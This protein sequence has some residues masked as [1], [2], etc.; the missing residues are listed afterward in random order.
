MLEERGEIDAFRARY[1]GLRRYLPAFFALPFQGEPGSE[2]ILQGLE[3]VRQLDA[4]T[5]Q[6]FP[7]LAPTAFVPGKFRPALAEPMG[8]SIGA[9]GNSGW[10]SRSA[11]ACVRGMSSCPRVAATSPLPT[12]SMIPPV[13]KHERDEAYTELQLP[14]EP[15]DFCARLQREFDDGSAA[16][17][18]GLPSQCLCDDP[19]EPPPSQKARSPGAAT[20][21]QSAAPHHR[22]GACPGC[23]SKTC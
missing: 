6:T 17:R 8:H 1:P 21:A 23:G 5:L 10:P 22:R 20:P 13:G 9:R 12:W 3:I 19:R 15:D 2:A 4:G 11:M 18:A 7:A 16:G 14:Q